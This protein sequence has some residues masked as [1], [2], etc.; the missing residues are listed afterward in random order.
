MPSWFVYILRCGDGSLYTG[1]TNNLDK[2]I[3]AHSAGRGGKYT[4]AHLPVTLVYS[5]R[6]KTKSVALKREI[7]IKRLSRKD[8]MKLLV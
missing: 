6:L 1:S 7:A 5:E 2:R 4:R 3:S 8:K